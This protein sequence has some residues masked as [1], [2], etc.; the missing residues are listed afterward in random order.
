MTQRPKS[1]PS[2]TDL[3]NVMMIPVEDADG[4]P[5]LAP[6]EEPE[7]GFTEDEAYAFLTDQPLVAA[8]DTP[9]LDD[10]VHTGAM[11]ALVPSQADIDRI[12][13]D[14]GEPPD[15]LHLTLFYLGDAVNTD[16]PTQLRITSAI[17]DLVT[18]QPALEVT[19]FGAAMWNPQGDDPSIIMNVGG[20][21]LEEIREAV[22]DCLEDVWTSRVPEQHCPWVPHICL[23]YALD[24]GL[25]LAALEKVGPITLDRVRVVWGEQVTDFPLYADPIVVEPEETEVGMA[26]EVIAL[27]VQAPPVTGV[28]P[29]DSTGMALDEAATAWEGIL[30]V[31]GIETGD[32][33]EFAPGSLDWATPPL[34]L[35]W[36]P[37]NLGEHQGSVVAARIDEV[38]R[39]PANANIIRGRG[40]FDIGG[41]DG[42]EAFRQVD[43]GFLKGVSVDVDSVKDADVEYVFPN[44]DGTE[45]SITDMTGDGDDIMDMLFATPDKMIFHRGRIRGATLVSLP[46]FV[47][48][49]IQLLSKAT[50]PIELASPTVTGTGYGVITHHTLTSDDQ[51]NGLQ[52][53]GR[54]GSYVGLDVANS[55]FAWV[56]RSSARSGAIH[57]TSARFLHHE[58]D[59]SGVVGP[60]NLTASAHALGQLLSDPKLPM[61]MSERRAAYEHLAAHVRDAGQVPQPFGAE[62]FSDELAGLVASGE[63]TDYELPSPS[64]F[65]DPQLAGPTPPTI[66]DDGHYFGH[67]A[68]WKSSHMSFQD[69]EVNPPREGVHVYFRLGEVLCSDGSRVAT[70]NITLGTGHAASV[71]IDPRRAIEHYDNTGTVVADVASGEDRHG[72]WFSGA[73]RSG[74]PVGRVAEL[75]GAKLSGDWRRI[76]GALRL[77]AML[78]VNVPGF[79]VPRMRIDVRNGRQLSLVAAGMVPDAVSLLASGDRAAIRTVADSIAR[80]IGRDRAARVAELK[81]RVHPTK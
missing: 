27:A 57:Q 2:L 54:L 15:E 21:G 35:A 61:T 76:G 47:E 80:R 22:E 69:A 23:A 39:D 31:E 70:G 48:A 68:L 10:G 45:D 9:Y 44:E 46:A 16:L 50:G 51:W 73:V 1:S 59:S 42:A 81:A 43:S 52:A 37:A 12:R 33:R 49:Q 72:I 63:V 4:N 11:I 77:V 8:A 71:G 55:A 17:G 34:T 67:A 26:G 3:D 56:D 79:A 7:V 38:W 74:V 75:R 24:E 28:A 18:L 53:S 78:A 13:L 58:V 66:T 14:G 30:V 25:I 62:S 32:G 6:D 64:F 60:A 65:E 40:V 36:A 19:G 20:P 41:V 29:T 5:I